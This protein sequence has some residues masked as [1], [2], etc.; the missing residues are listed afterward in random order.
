MSA[1]GKQDRRAGGEDMVVLGTHL[2]DLMRLFAGDPQ[3]CTA[4]LL[5]NGR[6][7]T[8]SDAKNAT[9]DIG[10]IV[11][12]EITAQFKFKGAVTAT[13]TSRA[14]LR[15]M[16]GHWGLE[17]VGSK[18]VAR[19]LADIWPRIMIRPAGKWEADART[20]TWRPLDDDPSLELPAQARTTA[21]QNA[22]VREDWLAAIVQKREPA[23]SGY[24]AAAAVEMVHAVWRAGLTQ[25]RVSLP[26]RARSHEARAG[27]NVLGA[28]RESQ[29][30][31]RLSGVLRRVLPCVLIDGWRRRKVTGVSRRRGRWVGRRLAVAIGR[32]RWRGAW[33]QGWR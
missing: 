27:G 12:D 1:F 5:Q 20:D 31:R 14:R 24:N 18:G 25:A 11:G 15:E 9:E 3:S 21:A 19:I 13:F 16:T 7:A 23:C 10:P 17:L 30:D 6:P 26:L 8:I 4:V 2:F 33:R 28:K 29:P 32:G 22:R